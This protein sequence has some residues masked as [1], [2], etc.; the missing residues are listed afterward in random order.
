MGATVGRSEG[1]GFGVG[2]GGNV[3]DDF[4]LCR[5]DA[6]TEGR[7]VGVFGISVGVDRGEADGEVEAPGPIGC[8]LI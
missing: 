1:E 8:K 6:V 2:V 3:T 5:G 4:G 7:G